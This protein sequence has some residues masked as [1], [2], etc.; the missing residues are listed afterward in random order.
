MDAAKAFFKQAL[1][2]VGSVPKQVTTDGHTSYPRAVRETLGDQALH[3]TNKYRNNLLQP[4]PWGSQ[5][6]VL[7]PAWF[8][9]LRLDCPFLFCL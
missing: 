8:W 7:P 9:K 5:A 4:G 1:T 6:T 2:V 3:R